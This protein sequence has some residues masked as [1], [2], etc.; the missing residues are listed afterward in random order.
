V[1]WSSVLSSSLFGFFPKRSPTAQHRELPISRCHSCTMVKDV[2]CGRTRATM[3]GRVFPVF[4]NRPFSIEL[5]PHAF[6]RPLFSNCLIRIPGLKFLRS[7]DEHRSALTPEFA[8][9]ATAQPI[10]KCA[11]QSHRSRFPAGARMRANQAQIVATFRFSA[12]F[13]AHRY[14]FQFHIRASLRKLG[15][16]SRRHLEVFSLLLLLPFLSILHL[17]HFS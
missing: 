13:T 6:R 10:H 7:D 8:I 16:S 12:I 14:F 3:T 9:F 5:S 17:F 4:I 1:C 2:Y 15:T 11:Q